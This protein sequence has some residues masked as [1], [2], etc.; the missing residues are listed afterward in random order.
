MMRPLFVIRV[1][2][3]RPCHTKG[4]P[5]SIGCAS[6]FR[7]HAVRFIGFG[8]RRIHERFIYSSALLG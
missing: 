1:S 7:F 6:G 3:R 8:P 5:R 2:V 4:L